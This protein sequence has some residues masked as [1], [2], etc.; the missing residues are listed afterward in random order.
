MIAE[1]IQRKFTILVVFL[2]L[3]QLSLGGTYLA[4]QWNYITKK[5]DHPG[6]VTILILKALFFFE[7]FVSAT[8]LISRH[9]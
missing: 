4:F 8:L 2:I 1:S 3:F 9:V 7:I 6:Q 5:K